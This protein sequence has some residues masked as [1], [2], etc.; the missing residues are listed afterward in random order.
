MKI[1]ASLKRLT[2]R[3][4]SESMDVNTMVTVTRKL[5]PGY[6]IFKQTGFPESIPIPNRDAAAQIVRDIANADLIPHFV[7]LLMQVHQVGLMGRS[8][9]ISYLHEIVQGIIEHGYVYD[10]ENKLFIEDGRTRKTVNWSVL[11]EGDE[12]IFAFMRLDIVGNSVLVRNYPENIIQETYGN[13]K[14]IVEN[15]IDSRNGRIWNWEGDGGLVAFFFSN[16]SM[17]ATLSAM[18]IIHELFIFNQVDCLLD[19]PLAVRIA[20][21]C[22]SCQF[23]FDPDEIAKQDVIKEIVRIESKHTGPN[24]I[25]VSNVVFPALNELLLMQFS[26]LKTGDGQTLYNYELTWEK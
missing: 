1:N 2:A 21:H 10:R 18:E 11:R 5:V 22:G 13:L 17:L 6:N 7:N 20:V 16:K 24:S 4:L 15:S 14:Q 9:P 12:Y 23:S 26:P 25:T 3:A 8:Y 19:N